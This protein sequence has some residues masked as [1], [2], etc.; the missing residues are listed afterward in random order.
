MTKDMDT[1]SRSEGLLFFMIFHILVV[2]EFRNIM[3]TSFNCK[4]YDT[5]VQYNRNVTLTWAKVT[6]NS[7]LEK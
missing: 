6:D 5:L 1:K 7:Q 3:N 2:Y 4:L